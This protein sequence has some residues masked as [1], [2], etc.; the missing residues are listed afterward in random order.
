MMS[1]LES[2]LEVAQNG[3]S[4]ELVCVSKTCE[5]HVF[6]QAGNIAWATDSNAPF[7]FGRY[8]LEHTTLTRDTF[9]EVLESCRRDRLPLGE[10]LIAWQLVTLE[11]IREA[12]AHQIRGAIATLVGCRDGRTVF[13]DRGRQFA[14][15]DVRL[16][17][18]VDTFL[19]ATVDHEGAALL[20]DLATRAPDA[21]WLELLAGA[22]SIARHPVGTDGRVP[23]GLAAGSLLDGSDA[24][25]LRTGRATY[26]GATLSGDRT[27]W[28]GLDP[29]A[30]FGIAFAAVAGDLARS[31]PPGDPDAEEEAPPSQQLL[32]TGSSVDAVRAF[33]ARIS[34]VAG[35]VV[36]DRGAIVGVLPQGWDGASIL[37]LVERRAPLLAVADS[38]EGESSMESLGYHLRSVATAESR[39]WCFGAEVGSERGR[40][41][42]VFLERGAT[43]AL[44]WAYLASL[45]RHVEGTST[46]QWEDG[47]HKVG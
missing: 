19:T 20:A 47:W 21:L 11:E 37:D 7:A 35:A 1:P 10:T 29:E 36:V 23:P 2:L 16:T 8:L 14:S 31:Q 30:A 9:Q 39:L 33:V 25:I 38:A 18:P 34:E 45:G 24:V 6:V 22:N 26:L 3:A 17:F 40:T 28:C 32:G 5:L 42:W 41:I 44:G 12:L 4:G 27:V 46:K 43:H 15:Y 13:L